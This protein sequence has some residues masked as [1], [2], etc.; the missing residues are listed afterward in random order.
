MGKKATGGGF[1]GQFSEWITDSNG[2]MSVDIYSGIKELYRAVST[3]DQTLA[4]DAYV[5]TGMDFIRQ[6]VKDRLG[7]FADNIMVE[8]SLVASTLDPDYPNTL[9]CCSFISEEDN[10]GFKKAISEKYSKCIEKVSQKNGYSIYQHPHFLYD[11]PSDDGQ[12][13]WDNK[14]QSRSKYILTTKSK[15]FHDPSDNES[16]DHSASASYLELDG[17]NLSI[18][19]FPLSRSYAEMI[20]SAQGWIKNE[21][22]LLGTEKPLRNLQ[23][24]LHQECFDD[25]SGRKNDIRE[26]YYISFPVFGAIASNQLEKFKVG[27]GNPLQGIGACFIYFEPHKDRQIN[28]DVLHEQVS[29]LVYYVGDIIRFISVNYLFNL[30]LQLQERARTESIKSAKSAIMSRNMSHNLGSHVMAYLKQK[31]GSVASIL[32]PASEVLKNLYPS[33]SVQVKDVELPFLVGM[34]RFLGY[35]Q[36]RQDY[37]ATISTDYIPSGAPVNLKDAIYDE[38]NPD[39]RYMRH[40]KSP[41]KNRPMNILLDYIAKSEGL[42][43]ENMVTSG[44]NIYST[45]N[46]I[47][48]G[49]VRYYLEDKTIKKSVF[50]QGLTQKTM[51]SDNDALSV[52]RKINFNLPGGLIGRQALFSIIENL[53]RNAAKHGDIC[54]NLCFTFD[55]LDA[56]NLESELALDS[57]IG[58]DWLP[59]YLNATDR[60]QYY[61]LTITD[62][63]KYPTSLAEKLRVGLEEDYIDPITGVMKESNKGL[64]EIRISASW[65][66]GE[67]DEGMYQKFGHPDS[68]LL[69]PLVGI[70]VTKND[71]H[72]RYLFALRK[73]HNVAVVM[74]GLNSTDQA[75]F[76]FL[77]KDSPIEWTLCNNITDYKDHYTKECFRYILVPNKQ[78]YESIRP[79]APNRVII[80]EA[81]WREEQ[82]KRSILNSLA[83]TFKST[84]DSDKL[85]F[86]QCKQTIYSQIYQLFAPGSTDDFFVFDNASEECHLDESVFPKIKF[87]ESKIDLNNVQSHIAKYV[88]RTHHATQSLHALYWRMRHG[89]EYNKDTK[90]WSQLPEYSKDSKLVPH[91]YSNIVAIDGITGDNSSDRLVRREPL[92]EEWYYSHLRALKTRVAIFDERI[93]KIVHNI[94]ERVF[95]TPSASD[96]NAVIKMIQLGDENNPLYNTTLDRVFTVNKAELLSFIELTTIE[97]KIAFLKRQIKTDYK[98]SFYSSNTQS[99]AYHDKLVDVFTVIKGAFDDFVVIGC[100]S[101]GCTNDASVINNEEGKI[102]HYIFDKVA[103]ITKDQNRIVTTINSE[104]K[105]LINYDLLSIHQGLLDKIYEGF[106]I[107]DY[108]EG[109]NDDNKRMVTESIYNGFITRASIKTID[110]K[111]ESVNKEAINECFLPGMVIHSG[112]SKPTRVDMPQH[113][114]FVQYS[115]IEHAV[116]DCK[117]N[118]VEILDYAKY[119]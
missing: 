9:Q 27:S 101:C 15:H 65:L 116:K 20:N 94:D 93:F 41:E 46:D 108:D 86:N 118:L 87:G 58:E 29:K 69:L 88:Y 59:L 7:R 76:S 57:R 91:A 83:T 104:Y 6:Q 28:E 3:K 82:E 5:K 96:V 107:K 71:N 13:V 30:G 67:T 45:E 40:K 12:L 72:L 36:E 49:F 95:L 80:W 117:F 105:D 38:L 11:I 103:T 22:K 16:H 84:I 35:L 68:S 37:I 74:E 25:I 70:E 23:E 33:D 17:E 4:K 89:W 110:C 51:G 52:M 1:T 21:S 100:V 54:G 60:D 115:A 24:E 39:L 56:A 113:L 77:S 81:E 78:S 62:N 85:I 112:R 119:E 8:Y 92:T 19:A 18:G 10:S 75:I 90:I 43:R 61:I 31:L 47:L 44:D 73:N 97:D 50:G 32:N 66:R 63:L 102:Y 42:S 48:F 98:Q 99:A 26:S 53:I 111:Y 2:G 114:P 64:K 106:G 79:Y 34:G 14:E 109:A 55:V